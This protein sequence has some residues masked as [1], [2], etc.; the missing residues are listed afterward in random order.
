VMYIGSKTCQIMKY[1]FKQHEERT[2]LIDGHDGAIW[3]LATCP[4]KGYEHYY[5]TGGHDNVVKL[6][7]A[8]KRKVV[9]TYEFEIPEGD[10]GEEVM[11]AVWSNDGRYIAVGTM[12]SNLY[13]LT[14]EDQNDGKIDGINKLGCVT[15]FHIGA[16]E[17][18]DL[19]EIAQLRFSPSGNE[20]AVAHMDS[21]LYIFTIEPEEDP[22]S[23]I[24][25][26]QFY[27]WAA[28]PHRAAPTHIQWSEDGSFVKTFTRDYE[29]SHFVVDSKSRRTAHFPFTP[30]PDK[31]EW[32]DDPLIAGWEVEGCYQQEWDGTDLNDVTL[33]NDNKFCFTGDDFGLVRVH[34]YPA[35]SND[36][37][38]CEKYAGHSSFVVGVEMCRDD[39]FLISVG[40]NDMAIFQWKITKGAKP[41]KQ[42]V[43]IPEPEPEKTGRRGGRSLF[44]N[45]PRTLFQNG[46][47]GGARS[48]NR[49]GGAKSPGGRSRNGF[50]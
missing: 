29:I 5:L 32:S 20:L 6:W 39:K 41:E 11:C 44:Q 13:L 50:K 47:R 42:K 15:A 25:Y 26:V 37:A 30:D 16:K 23:G 43:V 9:D 19:E 45:G 1:D 36:P 34:N 38:H 33:S 2:V 17:G 28:I 40:G 12:A 31:V 3:G 4:V 21:N 14:W 18:R 27:Q 24:Q 10:K 35:I 46:P 22:E 48:P 7:D 49:R 8:D